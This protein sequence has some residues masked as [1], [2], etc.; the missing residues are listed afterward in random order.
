MATQKQFIIKADDY[1][2]GGANLD[3][4]RR[5]I[6]CALDEYLT[7]SIGVVA[8]EFTQNKAV[9]LYLRSIIEE[10]GIEVWNHSNT[11]PN[12]TKLNK[13]Q[14]VKEITESQKIIESEL[15]VRP[16]IFGPPFNKIDQ[17]SAQ[18]VFDTNEFT[19][20]YA[21][22]G[23]AARGR[24]IELKYFSGVEIG[25]DI[26][27]PMRLDVFEAEMIRREWPDFI[28]LQ[29]HPFYWTKN[30][31]KVLNNV[32][33]ELKDRSY[34]CINAGDRLDYWQRKVSNIVE[35]SLGRSFADNLI[36]EELTID[37]LES[38]S[39]GGNDRYRSDSPYYFRALKGGT[40]EISTYLRA[41]GFG[42]LPLAL[43]KLRILDVGA[44]IGNWSAAAA[45]L[46]NAK[47]TALDREDLHLGLIEKHIRAENI[48]IV[49]AELEKFSWEPKSYS[50]IICNNTI[51]YLNIVKAFEVFNQALVNGGSL[52][53]GLSNR[54]Y[55]L[56]DAIRAVERGDFEGAQ[57]FLE[58]LIDNEGAYV[59]IKTNSFVRYWNE[60]ELTRLGIL[61]GLKLQRKN[62]DLPIP[63]G[64]L[65]GENCASG[66]QYFKTSAVSIL[67]E[68]L[69]EKGEWAR[70]IGE[71]SP[72][73]S[74]DINEILMKLRNQMNS[75]ISLDAPLL[76][77]W[78]E[79]YLE[80]LMA[81]GLSRTGKS[82]NYD[83]SLEL[84][85]SCRA[86]NLGIELNIKH[87]SGSSLFELI[88]RFY[89]TVVMKDKKASILIISEINASIAN[90]KPTDISY[91]M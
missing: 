49:I 52:F 47:V 3:P 2:R 90:A 35:C 21:F 66:Y 56:R 20:Y 41:L 30:C 76:D 58:R 39:R 60:D 32:V 45:L 75:K 79:P 61:S 84:F 43:G 57:S 70:L 34:I 89:E 13:E 7:L 16:K 25:T 85:L 72:S 64:T 29:V 28:V 91:W 1:G 38:D 44:G 62:L 81:S 88:P 67:K 48:E 10:Y 68:G 53:L 69:V 24:N 40:A 74:L 4:W 11:H 77:T 36:H 42:K 54:L 12:F 83:K 5:F 37:F 59:G 31:L 87:Q 51:S 86:I 15:G 65:G 63:F 78:L 26:F 19:G 33:N 18:H 73:I 8:C 82:K 46:P 50:A 27:R 14:I 17:A 22:D 23:I 80:L 9:P 55:P 71:Y 6:D